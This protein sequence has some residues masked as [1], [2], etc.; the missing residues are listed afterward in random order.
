MDC[1][2]LIIF[3][4]LASIACNSKTPE[5]LLITDSATNNTKTLSASLNYNAV[6]EI[7]LPG[8]YTRKKYEPQSFSAWLQHVSVKKDKTVYLYDGRKK[9]NQLA[10]YAVLDI[11]V[12]NKDLQQCAD[13]VMRLRSEYL[14]DKKKYDSIE[15]FDNAGTAYKFS[16]PY[17]RNNFNNYL[18]R[19]F[20]MCGSASLA[21]QLNTKS[22][23]AAIEAGDVIIRGGFPGHAVIVMDV[24]VNGEG[25]KLYLLAQ[26]YMPAQDIHVLINPSNDDLSPWY[27]VNDDEKV[28]TPEYVFT[29]NELKTW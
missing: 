14:F 16:K 1:K 15:F 11:S 3:F 23:F 29:K 27:E 24:A 22:D 20:G 8:G 7:P 28:V 10:Q 4:I 13:A 26:S 12:G 19:V 6:N 17:E 9:N 5:K 21:K 18:N 2:P 25:K